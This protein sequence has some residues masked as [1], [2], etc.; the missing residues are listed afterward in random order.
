MKKTIYF[1]LLYQHLQ[2]TINNIYDRK[3]S[4]K[5]LEPNHNI[6]NNMFFQLF[7]VCGSKNSTITLPSAIVGR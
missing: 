2:E 5:T 3:H 7:V 4:L 1:K 6:E